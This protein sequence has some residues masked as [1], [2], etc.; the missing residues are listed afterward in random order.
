MPKYTVVVEMTVFT[1]V[2]VEAD[3]EEEACEKAEE[4]TCEES[5]NEWHE[6]SKR[7]RAVEEEEEDAG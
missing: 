1:E 3:S 4:K 6:R 5:L 7:I 2:K